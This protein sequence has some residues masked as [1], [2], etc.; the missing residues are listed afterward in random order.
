M[1]TNKQIINIDDDNREKCP[2]EID[3]KR[4]RNDMARHETPNCEKQDI[5][6]NV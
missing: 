2:I 1:T 3:E 5:M 4:K 6:Y